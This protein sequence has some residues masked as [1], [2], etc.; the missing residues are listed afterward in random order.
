MM[1][2]NFKL[3]LFYSTFFSSITQF[4]DTAI[5]ILNKIKPMVC[6]V[7]I[8]SEWKMTIK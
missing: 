1:V 4:N 5:E 6:A 7:K 3:V 2:K 8:D